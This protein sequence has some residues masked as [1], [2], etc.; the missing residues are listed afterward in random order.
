[1]IL[2]LKDGWIESVDSARADFCLV[3]MTW[4]LVMRHIPW[5]LGGYGAQ[6]SLGCGVLVGRIWGVPSPLLAPCSCSEH[7]RGKAVWSPATNPAA[8]EEA[9]RW[10]ATEVESGEQDCE[11]RLEPAPR[12]RRQ[13]LAPGAVTLWQE[14]AHAHSRDQARPCGASQHYQCSA[15]GEHGVMTEWEQ[16]GGGER[17]LWTVTC[18]ILLLSRRHLDTAALQLGPASFFPPTCASRMP[19]PLSGKRAVHQSA[20]SFTLLCVHASKYPFFPLTSVFHLPSQTAFFLSACCSF[21]ESCP[22]LWDLMGC[23]TPGFPVLHHLLEFAQTHVCWVDDAIQPSHPLLPSSPL[24]LSLSSFRVFP[25][26]SSLRIRWPKYCSF[27]INPPSEY[28]GLI[29][30]WIDWFDLLAVQ[31]T[32]QSLFHTTG[33]KPSSFSAEPSLWSS[34][35]IHTWLLEKP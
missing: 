1:M 19:S 29:S 32:L 31:G 26:K 28:S 6:R 4:V 10:S 7:G 33:S 22:S 2:T 15:G 30:F 13:I 16:K 21:A 24:A 34:S 8:P 5:R 35:H 25:S 12:R 11:H 3:L 23:S 9:A 18:S 14:G 17:V 27:S 20:L